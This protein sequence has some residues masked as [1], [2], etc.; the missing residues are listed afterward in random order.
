[1]PPVGEECDSSTLSSQVSYD[2][3]LQSPLPND[4]TFPLDYFSVRWE[5]HMVVPTTNI[6]TFSLKVDGGARLSIGSEVV[7]DSIPSFSSEFSG[8]VY[9]EKGV[10]YPLQLD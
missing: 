5:G 6:Y 1:M 8:D 2:W 3:G 7:I 10:Y 9:L 4:P